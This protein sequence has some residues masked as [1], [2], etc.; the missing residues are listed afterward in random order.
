MLGKITNYKFIT[1]HQRGRAVAVLPTRVEGGGWWRGRSA[2]V[3]LAD[4]HS[5]QDQWEITA[6]QSVGL[7]YVE[8]EIRD[9]SHVRWVLY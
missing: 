3:Y 6:V 8:R 4:D 1:D 2:D 7:G 9:S 5:A